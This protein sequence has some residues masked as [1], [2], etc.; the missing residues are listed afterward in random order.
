MCESNRFKWNRSSFFFFCLFLPS[1]SKCTN[2]ETI[3]KTEDYVSPLFKF[4]RELE[5]VSP[6]SRRNWEIVIYLS[7]SLYLHKYIVFE[8]HRIKYIYIYNKYTHIYIY[9]KY[10]YIYLFIKQAVSFFLC[11]GEN[12]AYKYLFMRG[13]KLYNV[14]II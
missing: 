4:L 3:S 10:I 2:F 7:V 5:N 8:I 6:L 9:I 11:N 1:S 13:Q 14:H 12:W